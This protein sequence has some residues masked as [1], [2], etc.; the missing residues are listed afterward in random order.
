MKK[1]FTILMALVITFFTVPFGG[2]TALAEEKVYDDIA[3]GEYEI[4]IEALH[5]TEDKSSGVAGNIANS[6]KLFVQDGKISLEV[7]LIEKEDSKVTK[8]Q[9]EKK[10][11]IKSTPDGNKRYE[12]FVIDDLSPI[13]NA[14]V[15]YQAIFGGMVVHEGHPDIR[16]ALDENKLLDIQDSNQSNEE[17]IGDEP[18]SEDGTEED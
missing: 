16:L 15:S 9:I 14:N 12:T 11:P 6:A 7:T 3:D 4:D 2:I 5:A 13:L 17:E 8:L 1:S 10:D 18:G